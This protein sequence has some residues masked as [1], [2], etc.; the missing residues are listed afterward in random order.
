MNNNNIL[1]VIQLYVPGECRMYTDLT[2][3]LRVDIPR[4]KRSVKYVKINGNYN[5]TQHSTLMDCNQNVVFGVRYFCD[6][7]D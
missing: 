3:S 2:L 1:S 5:I 6:S 7:V 4:L